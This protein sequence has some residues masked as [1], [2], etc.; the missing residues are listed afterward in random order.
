MLD[1][2]D[3]RGDR[4]PCSTSTSTSTA[5]PRSPRSSRSGVKIEVGDMLPSSHYAE[6]A[7]ARA[8]G[9]GQG[10]RSE[11]QRQRGRAGLVRR[12]RAGRPVRHRP[13]QPQPAARADCV[14]DVNNRSI[15]NEAAVV[16]FLCMITRIGCLGNSIAIRRL[17][18]TKA[19]K[20][21]HRSHARVRRTT[22]YWPTEDGF[23]LLRG[24]AG[25]TEHGYYYSANRFMCAEHGGTHIDAP[26]HSEG[27]ADRRSNSARA[28][29]RSGGLRRCVAKCRADRDYQV[30][31][32]DFTAWEAA[33]AATLK[34]QIVLIRTG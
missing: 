14:R 22:I 17:P 24:S 26:I 3:G 15:C 23:K 2:V 16:R 27:R 19:Q 9:L 12:I 25:V 20:S 33:N 31:V 4:A 32:E 1:A 8:A 34:D 5:W 28:F 29:G 10:V 13:H 21:R 18:R 6:L 30:T 11:R 7:E